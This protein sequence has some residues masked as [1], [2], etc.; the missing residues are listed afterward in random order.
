VS[1][2]FQFSGQTTIEKQHG[3]VGNGERHDATL[4]SAQLN[5]SVRLRR[6]H[7]K[8][9]AKR[10]GATEAVSGDMFTITHEYH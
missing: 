4:L 7:A 8:N 3:I 2:G 9:T 5:A 10:A 1:T 6:R